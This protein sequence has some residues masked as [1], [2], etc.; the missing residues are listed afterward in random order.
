MSEDGQDEFDSK[1]KACKSKE[2]ILD[3]CLGCI[4]QASKMISVDNFGIIEHQ[5]DKHCEALD[6]I[7]LE[8]SLKML[9]E[10]D[11]KKE[12]IQNHVSKFLDKIQPGK[13]SLRCLLIFTVWKFQDS[14]ITK[15][16]KLKSILEGLQ[17]QNLPLQQI[18]RLCILIFM[19]FCTF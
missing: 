8:K 15:I 10:L 4:D 1:I 6:L 16:F 9:V 19:N 12:V 3:I 18:Y 11:V 5:L 14:S 7:N 2:D 17:V 13:I